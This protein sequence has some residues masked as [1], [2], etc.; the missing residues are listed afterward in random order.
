MVRPPPRGHALSGR[1]LALPPAKPTG[2]AADWLLWR[3]S[4]RSVPL[5]GARGRR[6]AR[7]LRSAGPRKAS[8]GAVRVARLG[9]ISRPTWQPWPKRDAD[10]FGPM[11]QHSVPLSPRRCYPRI[12]WDTV[13]VKNYI[14]IKTTAAVGPQRRYVLNDI[15][16]TSW[17]NL[18]SF[19]TLYMRRVSVIYPNT[20]FRLLR[21][22]EAPVSRRSAAPGQTSKADPSGWGM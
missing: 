11:W 9:L 3:P 22:G 7:M 15:I 19:S 18:W 10:R 12:L 14:H 6:S 8:A 20:L 17:Q 21:V 5:I 1:W 16:L 4:L 2:R 13:P